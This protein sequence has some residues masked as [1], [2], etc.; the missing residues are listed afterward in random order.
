MFHD[1]LIVSV[2]PVGLQKYLGMS[3][4]S[5]I[6]FGNHDFTLD[7]GSTTEVIFSKHNFNWNRVW[8]AP[9]RVMCS[10]LYLS[11]YLTGYGELVSHHIFVMSHV[12]NW[13]LIPV[14]AP[15]NSHLAFLLLILVIQM[16]FPEFS[17]WVFPGYWFDI[18]AVIYFTL[19]ISTWP[20]CWLGF[21]AN[22]L[23]PLFLVMFDSGVCQWDICLTVMTCSLLMSLVS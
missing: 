16:A 1:S 4:G 5:E 15:P 20:G 3:R 6:M 7:L 22:L 2:L 21:V 18:W 19:S 12:F 23:H 11:G 10:W 9:F 8:K 17:L 14:I 13:F